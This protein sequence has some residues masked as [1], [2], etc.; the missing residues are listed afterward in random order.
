[1]APL[2]KSLVAGS[3]PPGDPHAPAVDPHATTTELSPVVDPLRVLVVMGHPRGDSLVAALADAYC[4]RARARGVEVRRLDLRTL[5][6]DLQ[7]TTADFAAQTVEDDVQHARDDLRWAQHLVI[8]YPLWWGAMPALLKGFLDRVLAPG[9]AFTV[10]EDGRGYRGLLHGRTAHLL[11]TMDTPPTI[12]RW[13]LRSPGTTALRRD[14]LGFCGIAPCGITLFGPVRP[15]SL[16]T[17][18]RWLRTAAAAGDALPRRVTRGVA[19]R[20][21]A[22]SWLRAMRLQ[23]YPMSWLAYSVGAWC[24]AGGRDLALAPYLWGYAA[25][26]LL[27]AAT[28]FS[29]D[30]IDAPSDRRNRND[31]PFNGGSRMLVDGRLTAGQLRRATIVAVSGG[32]AAFTIAAMSAGLP[33]T[34]ATLVILATVVLCLGYTVP[35]LR[36]SYRGLGELDVGVTHGLL[37][38]LIGWILQ[39]GAWDAPQ[40]WLLALPLTLAIVPSIIIANLPDR[41]ADAAVGKTTLPV[42]LGNRPAAFLAAAMAILAAVSTIIIASLPEIGGLLDGIAIPV[43]LHAALLVW[44]VRYY[45]RCGA[46]DQR[47]DGLIIVALTFMGWFLAV[48]VWHLTMR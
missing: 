23:F 6:F 34:D 26:F 7:V 48:P 25:L 27:E 46:P 13:L 37:V 12:Y 32:I 8:V 11:V 16:L 5:S 28:V 43:L 35:P 41:E 24:A 29:N 3:T 30:L 47:C 38:L 39:G 42:L 18:R 45:R 40:P 31:G 4:E 14:V 2:L 36:L 15:A 33:A 20:F 19:L 44:M 21:A 9:L 10:R 22:C 17:R 1:M